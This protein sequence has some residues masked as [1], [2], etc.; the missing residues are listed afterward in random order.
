MSLTFR[1]Y[2]SP[3]DFERI[4]DF[5]LSLYRPGNRDGNWFEATWEYMHSHPYLDRD[6]LHKIGVWENEVAIVGVAHYESRLGE[7]FFELHPDY[8]YLK[9]QML[10]YSEANLYGTDDEGKRFVRAYVNSFDADFEA[11][12]KARGYAIDASWKRPMSMFTIPVPFPEISLPEGFRVQSLADDCDWAKI[13]RV[14]WRGFNHEGEPPADG[15][16]DRKGMELVP[17]YRRD[18]KIVTVAPTGDFVSFCGMWYD[19]VNKIAY[20]EPVAT[21][22]DYRRMGLGRAAVWEGVRRCGE[23]GATVAFV[24]SDQ[25]FYKAIGFEVQFKANCWLKYFS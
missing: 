14:L 17:N 16:E 8:V 13:H 21:D 10:D 24:G 3:D 7:V 1:H 9:L 6:S 20:V 15:I 23:L 25:A 22:P 2:Q 11:E 4:C 5:L 18:L 12:V 19:D